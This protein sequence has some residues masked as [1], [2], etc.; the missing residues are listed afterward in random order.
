MS[1]EVLREAIENLANGGF[2]VGLNQKLKMCCSDINADVPYRTKNLFSK[3]DFIYFISDRPHL[4][5]TI[6]NN[7]ESSG[8]FKNTRL[9]KKNN[10]H[11]LWSHVVH[12]F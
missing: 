11:I 6:H 12:V 3:G 8:N 9:L 2:K 10:K 1:S 4:L 5:K 7:F